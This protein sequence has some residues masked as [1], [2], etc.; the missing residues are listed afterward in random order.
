MFGFARPPTEHHN[1]WVEWVIKTAARGFPWEFFFL[2]DGK[3]REEG[4]LLIKIQRTAEE[5]HLCRML[6]QLVARRVL[7]ISSGQHSYV[8]LFTRVP[9]VQNPRATIKLENVWMSQL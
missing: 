1:R 7:H 9:T 2:I 3:M 5:Q 6:N 4:G 8:T